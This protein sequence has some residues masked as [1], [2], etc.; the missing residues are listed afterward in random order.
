MINKAIYYIVCL[1]L[2]LCIYFSIV[3]KLP[4]INEGF[5]I[6][7]AYNSC[8][9]YMRRNSNYKTAQYAH[10]VMKTVKPFIPGL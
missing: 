6:Q 7:K 9:R 5:T 2:L 8:S 4:F 1:L 10:Y 3:N